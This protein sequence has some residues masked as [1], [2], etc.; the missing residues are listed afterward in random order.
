M[1]SASVEMK[2]ATCMYAYRSRGAYGGAW[3][4]QTCA[5]ISSIMKILNKFQGKGPWVFLRVE[6]VL[7]WWTKWGCC[8][9]RILA[10]RECIAPYREC[11]L[12]PTDFASDSD[13]KKI[14]WRWKI[15]GTRHALWEEE[16]I[17]VMQSKSIVC[18]KFCIV[19]PVSA[20]YDGKGFPRLRALVIFFSGGSE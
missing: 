11:I 7:I 9:W 5:N 12:T 10:V 6:I 17:F 13:K 16:K 3:W 20:M 14:S 18:A 15:N 19:N 4:V 1:P 8:W 2:G